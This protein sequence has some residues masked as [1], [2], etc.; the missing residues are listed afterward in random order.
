[1]SVTIPGQTRRVQVS[2]SLDPVEF[3][4]PAPTPPAVVMT[5]VARL[6]GFGDAGYTF[7]CEAVGPA[8]DAARGAWRVWN[9]ARSAYL[10][11]SV[12]HRS[13]A[14]LDFTLYSDT[15]DVWGTVELDHLSRGM[16]RGLAWH[17]SANAKVYTSSYSVKLGG[18]DYGPIAEMSDV[19]APAEGAAG[20][21][22]EAEP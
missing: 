19:R 2:I 8:E 11:V 13:F 20:M 5:A 7:T 12:D 18:W 14:G 1:M 9:D 17:L 16:A 10:D 6:G 3:S 21:A 15:G 22:V 4:G